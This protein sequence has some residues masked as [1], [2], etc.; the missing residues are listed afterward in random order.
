MLFRSIALIRHRLPAQQEVDA[1]AAAAFAARL[2]WW[3][4][5]IDLACAWVRS[6][7]GNHTRLPDFLARLDRLDLLTDGAPLAGYPKGVSGVIREL[8]EGL[9][10]QSRAVLGIVI[11]SGGAHVPLMVIDRWA[12]SLRD[13]GVLEIDP[14]AALGELEASALVT[15]RLRYDAGSIRGI[16][17]AVYVHEGIQA[18]LSGAIGA[19]VRFVSLWLES[20]ATILSELIDGAKLAEAT[21]LLPAAEKLLSSLLTAGVTDSDGVQP[22]RSVLLT[23]TTMM[24]NLGALA[25]LTG[26]LDSAR[27][28]LRLAVDTREK[29][30]PDQQRTTDGF[31]ALQIQSLASLV[32]VALRQGRIDEIRPVVDAALH[33]LDGHSVDG[34]E[35]AGV[36]IMPALHALAE[37]SQYAA[38]DSTHMRARIDRSEERRVGKECPV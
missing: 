34:L 22:L 11:I 17:E 25:T 29:I 14:R 35:A 24:H 6:L 9:S 12:A 19:D 20:Y 32:Q 37:A 2:G 1:E 38:G 30:V 3:P 15:R 16:D 31:A 10:T 7:G 27:M 26:L 8:W 28:W 5:A 23:A 36:Q 18:V 33:Y 4:L 21:S 13:A